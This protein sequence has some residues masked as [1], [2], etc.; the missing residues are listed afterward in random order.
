MSSDGYLRVS[1]WG[2]FRLPGERRRVRQSLEQ[3]RAI[4]GDLAAVQESESAVSESKSAELNSGRTEFTGLASSE[5]ESRGGG[6]SVPADLSTGLLRDLDRDFT[7]ELSCSRERAIDVAAGAARGALWRVEYTM[8]GF[9]VRH[10]F[11]RTVIHVTVSIHPGK[12]ERSTAKVWT[13]VRLAD[14]GVFF[15][16]RRTYGDSTSKRNKIVR[17]L[18]A[19]RVVEEAD[20][21]KT[22]RYR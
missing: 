3:A 22:D 14:D 8:Y 5:R 12:P 10:F 13:R 16:S 9:Y 19:Y 7:L 11:A 1:G 17:R 15:L 2:L 20:E 6:S 21:A 18:S 4:L